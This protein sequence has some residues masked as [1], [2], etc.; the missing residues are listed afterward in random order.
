MHATEV[1]ELYCFTSTVEATAQTQ[2][3]MCLKAQY[4]TE[5]STRVDFGSFSLVI[6]QMS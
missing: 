6:M 4:Y 1:V 3:S 5:G 2:F